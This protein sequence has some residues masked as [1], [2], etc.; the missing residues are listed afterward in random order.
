MLKNAGASRSIWLLIGDEG[1]IAGLMGNAVKINVVPDKK[2][3]D[4]PD[5]AAVVAF[6]GAVRV[7]QLH[8][9]I[10]MEKLLRCF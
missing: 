2:A 3:E 9:K 7:E 5:F 1:H 6:A 10:S 4:C 8:E